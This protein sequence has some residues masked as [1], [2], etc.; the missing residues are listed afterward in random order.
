MKIKRLYHTL[1][2]FFYSK[3]QVQ[4]VQDPQIYIFNQK[5]ASELSWALDEYGPDFL[6][7]SSDAQAIALAYAGHQYG[8]FTMLGDG[9]ASYMGS[10]FKE[11]NYFD[12]HLKGSGPTS[13]SRGGDGK[14]TLASM[15]KEYICS[16]ALH[17]LNIPSTR[18]LAVCTTGESIWRETS[19]QGGV[20]ARIAQTHVRFGTFEYAQYFGNSLYTEKLLDFCIKHYYPHMHHHK[21]PRVAWFRSLAKR[22]ID[23]M[24][25]WLRVGFVH[26]VMNTDNMSIVG[27]TIDF[28][29]CAFIDDFDP[30]AVFSFIDRHGRYA[31]MKQP[32]IALWNLERLYL[33]LTNVL[34]E[35]E[36]SAVQEVLEDFSSQFKLKYHHMLCKKIGLS[37]SS[38]HFDLAGDL[39]EWMRDT[40]ADYTQTFCMLTHP[41]GELKALIKRDAVFGAWHEKWLGCLATENNVCKGKMERVNPVIIP[42]NHRVVAVIDQALS[43]NKAPLEQFMHALVNPYDYVE[44]NREYRTPPTEGQRVL[45]TYC[46]T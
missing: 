45:Y 18:S 31:W 5:L 19:H 11:G 40:K 1:P 16:E 32:N 27:E 3:R 9:R 43:G 30:H 23:L 17:G 42:R 34:S 25:D 29:P 38:K 12:V 41:T 37:C 36:K 2:Q 33:S 4:L 44:A 6:C 21:Q 14:A 8:H 28:G 10:L 26:G 22:Y 24:V 20:L 46:G 7:G 15:L 35:S 13:Y 39:L